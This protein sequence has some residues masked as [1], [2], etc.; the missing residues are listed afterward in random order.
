[1]RTIQEGGEQ[2]SL[3]FFTS[4]HI[5]IKNGFHQPIIDQPTTIG[6]GI[7]TLFA[8]EEEYGLSIHWTNKV[9]NIDG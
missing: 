5:N 3:Y 6:P 9:E 4:T 1:M 8:K 2:S 7:W